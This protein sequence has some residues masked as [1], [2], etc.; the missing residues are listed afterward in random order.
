MPTVSQ[1]YQ[2]RNRL[3][4][5]MNLG[6]IS[7]LP[8][9]GC[10][11]C[12]KA[13]EQRSRFKEDIGDVVPLAVRETKFFMEDS[14]SD[15]VTEGCNWCGSFSHKK[16]REDQENDQDLK[17]LLHWKTGSSPSDIELFLTGPAVKHWWNSKELLTIVNGVLYYTLIDKISETRL[18]LVPKALRETVLAG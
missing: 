17:H 7:E 5:A 15:K 9:G 6:R 12:Q 4:I 1:E 8:C 3:V 14:K 16:L 10:K 11:Y 2:P 13:H 18:L